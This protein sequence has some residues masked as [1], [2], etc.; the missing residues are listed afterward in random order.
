VMQS[1]DMGE[2]ILSQFLPPDVHQRLSAVGPSFNDT[3]VN[4]IASIL[5]RP[6]PSQDDL[7]RGLQTLS[8]KDSTNDDIWP[9]DGSYR[10]RDELLQ[11]SVPSIAPNFGF[12]SFSYSKTWP[13]L[14]GTGMSGSASQQQP[15]NLVGRGPRLIST[16]STTM[17]DSGSSIPAMSLSFITANDQMKAE[18]LVAATGT[19]SA[20]KT[21]PKP[22]TKG[23]QIDR[24]QGDISRFFSRETSKLPLKIPSLSTGRQLSPWRPSS[25]DL[26]QVLPQN[27]LVS[28]ATTIPVQLSSHKLPTKAAPFKRP[29]A[30]LEERPSPNRKRYVFLSSSPTRDSG[31]SPSIAPV[32]DENAST[33]KILVKDSTTAVTAHPISL[34]RPA[35]TMHT[36][37]MAMLRQG[38]TGRKTLGVR[39]TMNGWDN[40]RNK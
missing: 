40:R 1:R 3:V 9:A 13:E 21:N 39:R 15:T 19:T 37:S 12:S 8:D 26:D 23:R 22:Q 17:A 35:T 33:S 20:I 29:Q 38:G 31:E 34:T 36:T 16:S 2:S 27:P 4:D 10:P 18:K 32:I 7:I 30:A 6:C 5:R 24:N 11:N 25:I 14:Q 28:K